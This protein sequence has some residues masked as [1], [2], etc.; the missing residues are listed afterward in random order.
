[1]TN[2]HLDEATIS[3]DEAITK[4][5]LGRLLQ[6]WLKACSGRRAGHVI[7]EPSSNLTET[8]RGLMFMLGLR[9]GGPS[10]QLS[11]IPFIPSADCRKEIAATQGY[12]FK[13]PVCL[14][15]G[16]EENYESIKLLEA[17]Y[18]QHSNLA[19]NLSSGR[20]RGRLYLDSY[21]SIQQK[22]QVL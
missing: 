22:S 13:E 11:Q 7:H 1:M 3:V 15:C 10:T 21:F 9:C 2:Q 6:P 16:H 14:N 17:H 12:R 5:S 20:G 19:R 18:V 8:S 4:L